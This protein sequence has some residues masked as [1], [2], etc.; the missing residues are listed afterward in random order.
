M[1]G[2]AAIESQR[3]RPGLVG[4]GRDVRRRA[5]LRWLTVVDGHVLDCG[6]GVAGRVG[7]R[8]GDRRRTDRV[9]LAEG[10]PVAARPDDAADRHVVGRTRH[11]HV[12]GGGR[13]TGIGVDVDVAG[14]RD[15]GRLG[16][17]HVEPEAHGGRVAGAVGRGDAERVVA[18]LVDDAA[19]RPHAAVE[20]EGD[21][22]HAAPVVVDR[23]RRCDR[24]RVPATVGE[25]APRHDRRG[26][27]VG[28]HRRSQFVADPLPDEA[29]PGVVGMERAVHGPLEEQRLLHRADPPL[30]G[31]RPGGAVTVTR[32]ELRRVGA[33]VPAE[34]IGDPAHEPVPVLCA[35]GLELARETADHVRRRPHVLPRIDRAIR[36]EGVADRA[37]LSP[38][39]VADVVVLGD[40]HPVGR[41]EP[42]PL[43]IDE[44]IE[45]RGELV[46]RRTDPSQAIFEQH[47]CRG[48]VTGDGAQALLHDADEV[49][50]VG[51]GGDHHRVD[52]AVA[53]EP[54]D[55]VDLRWDAQLRLLRAVGEVVRL[56][57]VPRGGLEQAGDDARSGA[58]EVD[59][60]HGGVRVRLLDR[61]RRLG[62]PGSRGAVAAAV[63]PARLRAGCWLNCA[64]SGLPSPDAD[65]SPSDT[66][67][68]SRI[69]THC[70]VRCD[71]TSLVTVSVTGYVPS[72]VNCSD[73]KQPPPA[74]MRR[75]G[76]CHS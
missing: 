74:G 46:V 68:Q 60:R 8:P 49:Q 76:N 30:D 17:D 59:E 15:G 61:E 16:V 23:D 20:P 2:G 71:P 1:A 9:R 55:L 51:A 10:P 65:E 12:D 27:A 35:G 11:P 32:A 25:A 72:A 37:R 69:V 56:V 48:H 45:T 18:D 70:V 36:R 6:C 38:L 57:E 3:V 52:R 39:V 29:L 41:H 7:R 50:V 54:V 19:V 53:D 42:P 63:L 44:P 31:S 62:G 33:E 22:G 73:T 26:S 47:G 21:G 40:E 5:E 58:G 34:R 75:V 28:E 13:P 67:S 66:I 14:C 24:S 4:A 64:K 43:R